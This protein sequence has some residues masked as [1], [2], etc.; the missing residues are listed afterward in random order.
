MINIEL[1]QISSSPS[2]LMEVCALCNETKKL[3]DS[4]LI[5]KWIYKR[6]QKSLQGRKDPVQ[7]F[8]G[9]AFATSAQVKGYLLCD[10]C[11]RLFGEKEDYIAR[12]TGENNRR[13][14]NL[15]NSDDRKGVKHVQ[16][17]ELPDTIKTENLIYFATS[18]IW[19]ASVMPNAKSCVLG[20][21]QELLRSYLLGEDKF[22]QSIHISMQIIEPSERFTCPELVLNHPTSV[23]RNFGWFH[24]FLAHGLMFRFF[25]GRSFNEEPNYLN[26]AI[27]HEKKYIYVSK[28]ENTE[29]F[30]DIYEA[31]QAAIP[32]GKMALPQHTH[33]P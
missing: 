8:G 19:R 17:I 33:D 15:I 25:M 21:Y 24:S 12:L 23:K 29:E 5:P 22:P 4:H 2:E 18:I 10:D 9:A 13:L 3:Q 14:N 7:V 27:S 11:E 6:L 28:P 26:L 16:I 32:R 31:V 1:N 30:F 20:K